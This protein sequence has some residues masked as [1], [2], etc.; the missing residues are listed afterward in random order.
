M[1]DRGFS[2]VELLVVMAIMAILIGAGIQAFGIVENGNIKKSASALDTQMRMVQ[3]N[4]KNIYADYYWQ[5]VVKNEGGKYVAD[6]VRVNKKTVTKP[7]GTTEEATD[8]V[9]YDSREL[10]GKVKLAFTCGLSK[11]NAVIAEDYML[12]LTFHKGSGE[13]DRV[14]YDKISKGLTE[15]SELADIYVK[16]KAA[17]LGFSETNENVVL[18]VEH[19]RVSAE[20]SLT[21]YFNTGRLVSR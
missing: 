21:V 13:V 9:A 1:N 12:V 20:K 18:Y 5:L 4:S 16:E 3:E 19:D 10:S 15:E 2:L 7:D 6:V 17:E 8:P 14:E 11:V